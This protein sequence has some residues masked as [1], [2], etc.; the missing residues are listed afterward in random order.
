MKKST[1]HCTQSRFCHGRVK[2]HCFTLIKLLMGI[3]C[4]MGV[5]WTKT[6]KETKA[7]L[8]EFCDPQKTA[9]RP[10]VFEEKGGGF[11]RRKRKSLSPLS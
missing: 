3:A 7:G 4:K 8:Q 5:L 11:E 1:V 2:Q 6:H 9:I 10:K